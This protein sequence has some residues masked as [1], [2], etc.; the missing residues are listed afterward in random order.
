MP[1][2]CRGSARRLAATPR[3]PLPTGR[4]VAA[5]MPPR[6]SWPGRAP[7]SR[8]SWSA[9]LPATCR[10]QRRRLWIGPGLHVRPASWFL[11]ILRPS[12]Q[13]RQPKIGPV[14]KIRPGHFRV[15]SSSTTAA[16][17]RGCRPLRHS[18]DRRGRMPR[19]R[20]PNDRGGPGSR[21]CRSSRL[22]RCRRRRAPGRVRPS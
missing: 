13:F 16:G 22:R 5:P 3:R 9:A 6:R 8:S 20:G 19:C 17:S 2:H 21:G 11:G 15:R 4:P 10:C 18:P 14:P 7:V 12:D 1:L